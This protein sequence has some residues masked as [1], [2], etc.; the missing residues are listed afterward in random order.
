MPA[1]RGYARAAHNIPAAVAAVIDP[2]AGARVRDRRNIRHASVR[3]KEPGDGRLIGWDRHIPAGAA[4]GIRP[5]G[6]LKKGK[7]G[8]LARET[9][10][11]NR[12][13]ISGNGR[14]RNAG[15]IA[16]RDKENDASLLEMG[17]ISGFI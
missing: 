13:H 6:M 12:D 16:G 10:A 8:K 9:R 5:G 4:A 14:P 2:D 1:I 17:V 11:A 15:R 7:G 3:A